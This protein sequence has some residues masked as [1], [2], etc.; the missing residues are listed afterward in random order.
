MFPGIYHF[1]LDICWTPSSIVGSYLTRKTL[2]RVPPNG[3]AYI[4]K[5]IKRLEADENPG[6]EK[7]MSDLNK[8][9]DAELDN[10]SGGNDGHEPTWSWVSASVERGYLALRNA[11]EWDD[12]NIIA[13]IQNG[14]V[15]QIMKKRRHGDYVWA[16]FNGME[17]WVNKKYTQPFRP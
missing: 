6:K 12:R 13:Q 9:N 4:Y 14:T 17:G 2:R 8:L 1:L 7:T 10:V 5:H 3:M 15:F 11:P 16:Y